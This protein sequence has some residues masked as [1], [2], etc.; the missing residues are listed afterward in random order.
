MA[1]PICVYKYTNITGWL[2]IHEYV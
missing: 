2:H 1:E